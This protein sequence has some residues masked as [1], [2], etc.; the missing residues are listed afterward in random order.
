MKIQK[1]YDVHRTNR[2][3]QQNAILQG[4]S[5]QTGGGLNLDTILQRLEDPTIE[6]GFL[7]PRYS[8]VFWARP[9]PSVKYLVG[10]IQK[11]LRAAAPQLWLMP[12]DNLHMT[13]LEVAH[14]LPEKEIED[15]T[16]DL[17]EVI[18][19]MTTI[20]DRARLIK[21]MISHDRSAIAMSFLPAAGEGLPSVEEPGREPLADNFTY[22]HLRRDVY[23]WSMQTSVKIQSRYIVP[24]AHATVGRFLTQ[25]DHDTPEKMKGWVKAIN[26]INE[27]LQEE[28]WPKEGKGIK[29]GGEWV[30]G[31]EGGLICRNGALWYGGGKTVV[32]EEA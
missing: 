14:S 6:P 28:Y 7:D 26:D 30:V 11:R 29:E 17:M 23:A 2:E 32:V 27:W 22:H 8:L 9:P 10:E 15:I 1:L 5:F 13:V 3:G 24:S 12:K 31:R 16:S 25:N 18:T 21:P 4:E 20:K 19:N